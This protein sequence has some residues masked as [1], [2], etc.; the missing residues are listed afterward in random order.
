MLE[1]DK[2]AFQDDA[3]AAVVDALSCP[4]QCT[5]VRPQEDNER[6][7]LSTPKTAPKI[8]FDFPMDLYNISILKL[9]RKSMFD[10]PMCRFGR[11]YN[12]RFGADVNTQ[13]VAYS[14]PECY[15]FYQ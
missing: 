9:Q 13:L 10:L 6:V 15:R 3:R 2:N 12:N 7:I 5:R 8:N 1:E 14:R 11:V 4:L